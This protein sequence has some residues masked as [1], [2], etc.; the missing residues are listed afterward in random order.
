MG[1]YD[2]PRYDY[3]RPEALNAN[4][5]ERH[6]VVIVGAGPVGLSAAADFALRGVETVVLDDDDTV[7]LGS[8]AICWSKRTLEIF[9]RLGAGERMLDTGV[10][11]KLGR[12][13][14]GED[15]LY[16]FDML[17]EPGHRMPAFVNLQQYYTEEYLVDR[18]N[19]LGRTEI[20]WKN[21]V[22][23]VSMLEDGGA[24]LEVETPDGRYM[25]EADYVLAADGVRSEIRRQMGLDFKGKVFED[26]FLIADI[27]MKADFPSERWFWFEPPFHKGQ[28]VLLHRQADNVFRVDFQL[29]SSVDP[30]EEKKPENVIPRLKAMFGPEVAFDLEWVS[31]YSFTCRRMERF[32]HGPVFFVG[33]SAH[34]VSPFGARGGNGGV[35]DTDNLVWKMCLVMQGAAPDRLLD[36]YDDERLPATDENLLNSTRSTDFLTPKSQASLDFRQAVLALA[37]RHDFARRLVNSGRLSLPHTY[38]DTPLSTPDVDGFSGT[39][40]PGSPA[41]D[42]PVAFDGKAGWLLNALDGDFTLMV[43]ADAVGREIVASLAGGSPSVRTLLVSTQSGE[44]EDGRVV[45]DVD[46]L[47]RERYDAEPGTVYLIRPDQHVAA[48][49]R[50]IDLNKL[51][52]ALSRATA[53]GAA[54]TARH[55]VGG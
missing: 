25:I 41:A 40:Q 51:Q 45:V 38:V 5:P 46:G 6:P 21:K 34:V 3:V 4:A 32:R 27:Q 12:I 20:R 55:A 24:K 11:W 31:V 37:K 8:R 16:N 36:T 29:P 47:A 2:Y 42:A 19:E 1:S 53:T 35:Q 23:G 54:S 52:A 10:L 30:D 33:D 50:Q 13:F 28:S 39:M 49:W 17:P 48:R 18:V 14:H 43:F 22:I 9:D 15:E 44:L 26:R 7:S